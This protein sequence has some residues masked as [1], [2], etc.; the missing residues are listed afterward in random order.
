MGK[1]WVKI[2]PWPLYVNNNNI[3]K[4]FCFLHFLFWYFASPE[5]FPNFQKLAL[6]IESK[7]YQNEKK[8]KTKNVYNVIIINI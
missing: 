8:L 4:L 7:K 2:F 3:F 1:K 5:F 6:K